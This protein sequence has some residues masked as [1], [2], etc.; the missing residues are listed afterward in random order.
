MITRSSRR[1][2]LHLVSSP[3]AIALGA[4]GQPA[5]SAIT[6]TADDADSAQDRLHEM[7]DLARRITIAGAE[8]QPD[9]IVRYDDQLRRIEDATLWAFVN[10]G[11]PTASLKVEIY[12]Q[13]H[14]LYGLV[15]LS[16]AIIKAECSD[17]WDWSATKPGVELK[18]VPD[19]PVPGATPVERLVQMRALSRRFSGYEVEK[20][21]KG[22]FQMRLMTKPVSRYADPPSGLEDGA[23]FS[24]A[25]GTNPDVLLVIEARR[26]NGRNLAWQYGVARMGGATLVV[27]LDNTQVWREEQA[28]PIPAVRPTYMNRKFPR[29][30]RAE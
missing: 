7:A 13:G 3:L 27:N 2:F 28:L 20:S 8:L 12:R 17:G 18:P 22:R 16:D 5:L 29:H 14:A 30:G 24:L 9:P 25:N 19:A 21:E 1:T 15:S 23:L 6:Q 26:T 10:K 11:R 4:W